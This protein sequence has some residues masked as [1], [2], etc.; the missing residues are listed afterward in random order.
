MQFAVKVF[1]FERKF[2]NLK[3]KKNEF[4]IKLYF[5]FVI[6]NKIYFQNSS[7][8]IIRKI[9]LD[10][11]QSTLNEYLQIRKIIHHYAK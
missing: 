5:C 9:K 6:S 1:V 8:F 7:T 2:Y 11:R 3:K 4:W 10:T